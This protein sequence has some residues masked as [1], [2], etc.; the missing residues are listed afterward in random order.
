MRKELGQI[1]VVNFTKTID[2]NDSATLHQTLDIS[3]QLTGQLNKNIRQAQI[4][5]ICGIDI[6]TTTVGT[7]GGG[8]I[9]GEFRYLAP[10]HG[11]CKAYKAAYTAMRRAMKLQGIK[12]SVN[13]QYDFRVGLDDGALTIGADGN[14][15]PNQATLDSSNPLFMTSRVDSASVLRVYNESVFPRG[16]VGDIFPTGFNTMGVQN[17]PTDF[18]LGDTLLWAGNTNSASEE[19]ESIPFTLSWTPDTTDIAVSVDWRP[20]P[21]LYLAVLTG[22]FDLVVDEINVDGGAEEL[23]LNIAVSIAGWKSVVSSPR[24]R[25]KPMRKKSRT[26]RR[27]K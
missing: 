21:A 17:S 27:K 5:K 19:Y 7:V 1:H 6:A 16:N 9:S 2:S 20:D 4:F 26:S 22:Q 11:R 12:P 13:N 18:V 23:E 8:Q 15:I 25:K 10:T 24:K 3:G 14:T